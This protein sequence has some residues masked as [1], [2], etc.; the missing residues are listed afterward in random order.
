M[1][2]MGAGVPGR[3]PKE[4]LNFPGEQILDPE[5]ILERVGQYFPEGQELKVIG[6]ESP[7]AHEYPH[8]VGIANRIFEDLGGTI[9]SAVDGAIE[10]LETL[11]ERTGA[12]TA[13]V[14]QNYRT[15]IND[16][17]LIAQ[18]VNAFVGSSINYPADENLEYFDKK[19]RFNEVEKIGFYGE[20]KGAEGETYP[21]RVYFRKKPEGDKEARF[22]L[23]ILDKHRNPIVGVRVDPGESRQVVYDLDI[24]TFRNGL[25]ELPRYTGQQVVN[26]KPSH[27]FPHPSLR[28]DRDTFCKVLGVL[29]KHVRSQFEKQQRMRKAA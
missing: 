25:V 1:K 15:T 9:F 21:V 19:E 20:F 11:E 5:Q 26:G 12:A 22:N 18:A 29:E 24:E 6:P 16:L 7:L 28:L 8:V 10:R 27:H 23:E 14:T 3:Y 4:Q 13:E 17:Y 2:G